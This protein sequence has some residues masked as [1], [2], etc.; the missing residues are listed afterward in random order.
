MPPM[1]YRMRGEGRGPDAQPFEADSEEPEIFLRKALRLVVFDAE[2]FHD[3]APGD[4]F[5]QQRGNFA[6]LFLARRVLNRL[7]FCRSA[8]SGQDPGR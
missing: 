7:L 3:A 2:C 8:E 4:G 5:M 6:D 1:S